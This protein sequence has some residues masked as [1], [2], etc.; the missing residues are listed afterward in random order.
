MVLDTQGGPNWANNWC[1]AP[2]IVD[3]ENDEVYF[4]PLYYTMSHFSRYIRPGAIR[5]GFKNS[6]PEL[7]LTAF[8]N[9]D[10][11]IVVVILNQTDML[12]DINLSLNGNS[13]D[14]IISAKA[15]QTIV[16]PI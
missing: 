2:V 1:V 6:D 5:I 8:Q 12:K 13:T 11:S 16:I 9:P 4:T 14:F 15:I 3:P 7:L 10:R